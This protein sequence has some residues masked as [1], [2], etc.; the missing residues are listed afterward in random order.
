MPEVLLTLFTFLMTGSSTHMS[1][2][3]VDAE[4][5]AFGSCFRFRFK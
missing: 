1:A 4:R 5:A 3:L 2:T